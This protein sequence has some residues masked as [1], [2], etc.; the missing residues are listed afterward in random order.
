MVSAFIC[1]CSIDFD[2]GNYPVVG[3]SIFGFR[4][5]RILAESWANCYYYCKLAVDENVVSFCTC[6][7]RALGQFLIHGNKVEMVKRLVFHC[8]EKYR[9]TRNVPRYGSVHTQD[10]GLPVFR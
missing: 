1:V 4:G 7:L 6:D 5:I 3:W 9:Y 8:T 10:R 2:I